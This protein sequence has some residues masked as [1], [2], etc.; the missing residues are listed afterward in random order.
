M[1]CVCERLGNS[2]IGGGNLRAVYHLQCGHSIHRYVKAAFTPKVLELTI[3][4]VV[5]VV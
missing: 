3:M 4:V 2:F 1:V 5:D